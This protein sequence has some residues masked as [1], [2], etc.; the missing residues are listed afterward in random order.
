MHLVGRTS[1]LQAVEQVLG[2]ALSGRSRALVVLGEAGIGK[3]ALLDHAADVAAPAGFTVVRVVGHESEQ[4]LAFAG[5]HQLCAPLMEHAHVLPTP[6]RTALDVALGRGSGPT[7]DLFLVGLATLSLLAESAEHGPLLCLVDDGSL[8]DVASAQVIAFVARRLAAERLALIIATR[9]LTDERGSHFAGLRSHTIHPLGDSDARALLASTVRTPIGDVLRDR[10]VAE[11]RGNPLALLELPRTA[12]ASQL[13]SELA[14]P[15]PLTAPRRVEEAYRQRAAALPQDSRRLLLVATA[16]PTG[17]PVLLWAAAAHLGIRPDAAAAAEDAGLLEIGSR[18]SFP[19]P[20]ARSAVYGGA[21][22]ADRRQ[23]HD[24]LAHAVDTRTD[25][26]RRAWHRAN[27]ILGTDETVAAESVAAAERAIARGGFA[28]AAALLERA[29]ELTPDP[30]VRAGRAILAAQAMHEAGA[31]DQALR[32]LAVAEEGSLDDLDRARV[33]LYRAM[34]DFDTTSGDG[35]PARLLEAAET[36]APLDPARSR[37][38]YL[39]ALNSAVVVGG[40]PGHVS[41]EDVAAAARHAPAPLSPPEPADL[42]LDAL[43]SAYTNGLADAVTEI[44]HALSAFEPYDPA[45]EGPLH[46]RTGRWLVLAAR[47]AGAVLDDQTTHRLLRRNVERVRGAG[48][49][50][51]LPPALIHLACVLVLRGDFAKAA[52]LAA[53]SRAVAR[54]TGVVPLAS[55]DLLLAAW[56][57]REDDAS[58]LSAT[59]VADDA[60]AAGGVAQY[61]LA[62]SRNASGDY[63]GAAD[64]AVRASR[65]PELFVRSL[66]LHELAE[67]AVRGARRDDALPA[68]HELTVLSSACGTPMARGL[69]ALARALLVDD[70]AADAGTAEDHYRE[71]I[72]QLGATRMAAHLARAHLLHGEWLRRRGQ[73][74]AAR[75]EL[76]IAHESFVAMGA[77]VFAE[78]AARELRATGEHPRAHGAGPSTALTDHERHIARLVAAGATS[79]EVAAE[80]FLSPRTIEAHLRNIY[81]KLGITSRRQLRELL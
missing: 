29:T 39:L 9:E 48:S 25:P 18:V 24:A 67:G 81:R 72:D 66:A 22:P 35:A 11:A 71:A 74:Q 55:A 23:A 44:G 3:T 61:A 32:L 50:T 27:A 57:G 51:A 5:L 1:E 34:I 10:V 40:A 16:E 20:L 79:R 73:R 60:G 62:V 52:D 2:E 14:V 12:R 54:A 56:R 15:V 33:S 7:P 4:Q 46:E 47:T 70:S 49:L 68:L 37:E 42:L 17:D 69:A 77:A 64:A 58:R 6:Q 28:D 59:S 78:R 26:D 31:P 30:G 45:G 65:S 36:L 63:A 8:L 75:K 13:A 41:A 80:L 38:A 76:R 53:E 19:H 43:V 21:H